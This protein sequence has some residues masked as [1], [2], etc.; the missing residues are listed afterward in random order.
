MENISKKVAKSLLQIKAI[1]LSPSNFFT[2]ASGIKS[3]IY[4]DNR[5]IL[6]Y[7][8]VRR[9]IYEILAKIIEDKYPNIDIVAGVATGAIAHGVLAA[10]QL[11]KP[12]IYVR[13]SQKEHGLTNQIEGA[14][15]EGDRVVVV[16]DLI[17]TGGS[18]LNAVRALREAGCEVV[19]MIAIFS[20]GFD[21]A[22]DNFEKAGVELTT[23]T[24]YA[25]MIEIAAEQGY[26]E[27]SDIEKLKEW[28]QDPHNWVP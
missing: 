6:S 10:E 23:L 7:V 13:P 8:D 19:G 26:V 5:L 4:C 17:S 18:S 24:N 28:R 11:Q 1:K 21:E 22:K 15:K 3:P 12:F 2:W 14:Y 16:E 20:Y 25:D 27:Q 9:Q